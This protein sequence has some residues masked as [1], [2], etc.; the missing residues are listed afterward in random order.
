MATEAQ[1]TRQTRKEPFAGSPSYSGSRVLRTPCGAEDVLNGCSALASGSVINAFLK[2][3]TKTPI[4][5]CMAEAWAKSR[6]WSEN[7][8]KTCRSGTH[9]AAF[10]AEALRS[11]MRRCLNEPS[12]LIRTTSPSGDG[13]G[14]VP[15]KEAAVSID[16]NTKAW[17]A[18][19][20]SCNN[21]CAGAVEPSS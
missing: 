16:S 19:T 4:G 2:S 3:T 9:E 12:C 5:D 17:P 8:G 11:C 14:R 13:T 1:K 15:K 21:E 18:S 6:A 7:R 20:R 10:T